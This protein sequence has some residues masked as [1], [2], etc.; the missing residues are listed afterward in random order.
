MR[1]A[2]LVPH[3]HIFPRLVRSLFTGLSH[4]FHSK[5]QHNGACVC[6]KLFHTCQQV[7]AAMQVYFYTSV[8]KLE[9]EGSRLTATVNNKACKTYSFT[10][11]LTICFKQYWALLE[12]IK[13]Q[14]VNNW[15]ANIAARLS[16]AAFRI[17]ATVWIFNQLVILQCR[18]SMFAGSNG[19]IFPKA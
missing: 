4:F 1:N 2:F 11:Y 16:V 3:F 8:L 18:F 12:M 15:C 5:Q 17:I 19:W 9:E 7:S 13:M 6:F 14:L 10:A